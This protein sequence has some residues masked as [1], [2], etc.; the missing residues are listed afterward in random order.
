ME[1]EI[2]L[3]IISSQ[4]AFSGNI[5]KSVPQSLIIQENHAESA[6]SCAVGSDH[7]CGVSVHMMI[8]AELEDTCESVAH[9]QQQQT[10]YFA[11]L[12]SSFMIIE[13]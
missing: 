8:L 13:W 10:S 2:L 9:C 1:T 12:R 3:I 6:F 11:M 7:Y 5:P 4:D